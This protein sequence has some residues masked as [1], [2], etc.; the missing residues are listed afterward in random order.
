V[1]IG[2]GGGVLTRELLAA[3]TAKLTAWELDP[4]WA[5][6]L[7]RRL[8]EVR[9]VVGD[10]LDLDPG[11][12]RTP[13]L[14]CGNLPYAVATAIVERLLRAPASIPRMAFLVQWEVGRRLSARAGDEAYGA[15]SVLVAARARVRWLGRVA[16]GAFRPAPAVDGAFVG[17]EPSA[18]P[19]DES[20]M[21]GFERTVRLAFSQRRKT[22]RRALASGW[23]MPRAESILAAAGIDPR[24]RAES[25]GLAEFLALDAARR[26]AGSDSGC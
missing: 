21:A 9:V 10:A 6:E 23:G 3:G 26:R 17:L 22:L 1:E 19:L 5:F 2:A 7:R 15:L 18:L 16:R 4:A 25:L 11:R 24:R 20:E 8:P 13:T 12:L 14:V